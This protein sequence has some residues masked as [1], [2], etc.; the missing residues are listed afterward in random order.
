MTTKYLKALV[1]L[2]VNFCPQLTDD[3]V[4]LLS[5]LKHLRYTAHTHHTHKHTKHK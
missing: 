5:G 2:E 4:C 1:S 3:A